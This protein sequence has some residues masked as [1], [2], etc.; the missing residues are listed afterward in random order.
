MNP[1]A[2]SWDS[3]LDYVPVPLLLVDCDG[4]IARAN[5]VEC[6]LLGYSAEEM[7][8]KPLWDFIADEE[9]QFSQER[10][11]DLL[12]GLHMATS[13]RRRFKTKAHDYL[14]CELSVQVIHNNSVGSPFVLLASVDVTRQVAEA[15]HR[16]E[17]ARWFEASFRSQSEATMILDPLGRIR[18]LNR[19]AERL[20]GWS[21][22]EASGRIAEELI[23][24]S[25]ILSSDGTLSG[26][27]FRQG[28]EAGWSGSAVVVTRGSVAKKLQ[29][30][31]EP[32]V[33]NNG[34]VLGI[35][36]CLRPFDCR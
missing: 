3:G 24:W 22:A 28:V 6:Q 8:G 4:V 25:E 35:A 1:A 7:Q 26:Y 33:D 18:Y 21:D 2:E 17:I 14:V 10:F 32:V 27:E 15:C 11:L 5:P 13:Y 36:S 23:P 31:T 12:K 20:L 30:R 16:G 29:I 34:L 19:A 9:R